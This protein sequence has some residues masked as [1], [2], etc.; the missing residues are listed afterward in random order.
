M[1]DI[2]LLKQGEIVLKGQNKRDFEQRLINNVK[3]RLGKVGRFKVYAMQS[4]LYA[5]PQGDLDMDAALEAAKKVFGALSV[6]RAAACEKDKDAI[7]KTASKYLASELTAAKSFKVESKRSDKRFPMGSIELSQYVGGALHDKF[8]HL[9]PD[10]QNPELTV[11]IEVR[12][13]AAYVHGP[14][15]KGAGGLPLG[16]GGRM[17]TLL[18]GGIDSPVASYMIA[19]RGVQLI[20]VHFYSFPY[21]SVL[22]KEK[23]TKL[24]DC[25]TDYC[26]R[27]KV[28]FV[29]FT[30]IGEQIRELCPEGL[31]TVLMR[32][33]MM[34]I[35]ERIA[36]ENGCTAIV[37]GDN[38]GQ[39]A[40]QTAEALAVTEQ[41]VDIP[42]LRP[43]IAMD[44]ID[45][46]DIARKIETYETSILPY[47]DCCTVFTPKRPKTKPKLEDV[48]EAEAL[49]DV[50]ALIEEAIS[51]R[52]H[53]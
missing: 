18:S 50:E 24:A 14:A 22:A 25:L 3:Y 6:T 49:L 33:F 38:L 2:I 48:L 28:D 17:V 51:Y 41:C 11:H 5:E 7:I 35:A 1:K 39:V 46:I 53:E 31:L 13:L 45:I 37:T 42:V 10:M 20:P 32:R 21:T 4:T 30:K 16:T 23:V 34:R 52:S 43:L 47:D 15:L 27:L 36:L 8:P 40:S 9:K 29:S 12:D 19:K 26:G 44:K